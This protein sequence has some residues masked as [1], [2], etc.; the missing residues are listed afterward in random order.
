[1][2]RDRFLFAIL[3]GIGALVLVALLLFYIRQRNS[4]YQ[5]DGTPSAAVNNYILALQHQDYQRAYVY[6]ADA[7]N[8]PTLVKF[9]EPFL[10]YQGGELANTPVEIGPA[11]IDEQSQTAVIQIT[12]VRGARGFLEEAYRDSQTANLVKQGDT[13]KIVSFP[14]P[15]WAYDWLITVTPD[16]Q[17][18][19]AKPAP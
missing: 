16:V 6:L 10:Q 7:P 19:P 4:S 3:L 9:Q 18:V 13:W 11:I 5:E 8:K 12:L 1:M 15:Y 14:Y 17:L 2:K